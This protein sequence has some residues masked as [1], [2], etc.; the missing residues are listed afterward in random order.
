MKNVSTRVSAAIAALMMLGM[1]GASA[2]TVDTTTFQVRATVVPVCTIQANNVDFGTYN[3]AVAAPT[4]AT[5][6]IT[7]RC[8]LSTPFRVLLNGGSATGGTIMNRMMSNGTNQVGYQLFVDNARTSVW[9]D[10]AQ[11]V[12][13]SG[14][15]TGVATALTV[16]ARMSPNQFVQ[17]GVYTDLVTAT[18]E[19]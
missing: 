8:T 12:S 1:G 9:G 2:Q 6:T 4:D 14:V 5:S 17:A 3:A 15:G 10:G 13:H 11:G 7:V 19:Y 18:L 16:F